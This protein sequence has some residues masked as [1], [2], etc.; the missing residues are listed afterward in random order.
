MGE[1]LYNQ[2]FDKLKR[3]KGGKNGGRKLIEEWL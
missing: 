2:L 1:D 3:L